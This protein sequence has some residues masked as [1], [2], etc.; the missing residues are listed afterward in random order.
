MVSRL[1]LASTCVIAL[2]A[3]RSDEAIA[4]E[5][6]VSG[7]M[8]DIVLEPTGEDGGFRYTSR[9]GTTLCSGLIEVERRK[10][11][12]LVNDRVSCRPHEKTCFEMRSKKAC[13]RLGRIYDDGDTDP[14][15]PLERDPERAAK[16]FG[17]ACE[18]GHARACNALGLKHLEGDGVAPN[19]KRA[20]QFFTQSCDGK[21]NK[22][23]FNLGLSYEH[24]RGIAA[25]PKKALALYDKACREGLESGCERSR[26][27]ASRE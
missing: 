13:F 2:S 7:G 11:G 8:L 27:L 15:S 5:Y 4:R 6:L 12:L 9:Y 16:F 17:I 24:G 1:V 22:G 10:R 18:E 14:V 3:C 19:L 20:A 23:C 21:H 25:D 26:K